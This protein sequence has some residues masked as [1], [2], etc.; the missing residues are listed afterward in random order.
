MIFFMLAYKCFKCTKVRK[1]MTVVNIQPIQVDVQQQDWKQLLGTTLPH[2]GHYACDEEKFIYHQVTGRFF[3]SLADEE[4]YLEFLYEMIYESDQGIHL[5]SETLDKAISN[6][7]FQSIQKIMNIHQEEHGLSVNRF[8][9]FMEGEKLFPLKEN[10]EFYRHFRSQYMTLLNQFEAKHKSGLMDPNF[11]RF[12]VDTVKWSWNHIEKWLNDTPMTLEV[13]KV[14]WYGDARESEAYFLYFLIL[15]GFDVVIFHPEGKDILGDINKE[16]TP[17]VNYPSNMQLVPFPTT[18]PARKSTVAKKAYEEMDEVLHSD[19][20]L[21]Y[22][23]WQ[24]RSYTPESITLKTTYDEIFLIGR[25]KAFIR[26]NFEV[27]HHTVFIPSLFAKVLGVSTNK[28]EYWSRI[29]EMED[30]DFTVVLNTFPFAKE[31]KGNQQYHYQNALTNNTLDPEKMI[32]GNWWR[33]KHLPEGLQLGLARAISRFVDKAPLK[34][35][36]HET[37]DQL[38][39]YLFTMSMDLPE[40][41]VR[42]IQQFDY[43]QSIPK[44]LIFNNGNSG[45]LTRRDAAL[46]LL[47]NEIGLDLVIYNPTGQNDIELFIESSLFDS[48]WLDEFSFDETFE[49]QSNAPNSLVKKFIN[50]FLL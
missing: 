25:E 30:A 32:G 41:I 9:A 45:E 8:V 49:P 19:D 29:H 40:Q 48:H 11:R 34:S 43:S 28:K 4:E 22:R 35:L 17:I 24:F 16:A 2:R 50:K 23:P 44:V 47:L 37:L 36:E 10:R 15:L 18:R 46:L 42:L 21:L 27:K 5:L 1:E 26:P 12:I 14:L 7:M 38:R 13:P 39:L 6:E 33:N 31:V 3:G 20:S